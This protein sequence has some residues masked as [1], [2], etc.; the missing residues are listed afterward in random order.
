MWRKQTFACRHNRSPAVAL[1]ASAFKDEIE[2]VF[3]A[4]LQD[5]LFCHPSAD[6]V[7]ELCREL[8]SPTV[9]LEV[10]QTGA[11]GSKQRDEAMVARPSVVG[12][13]PAEG[14]M[15]QSVGMQIAHEL[16]ANLLRFGRNDNELFPLT[17]S[18]CHFEIAARYG[19]QDIAPVSAAM[20]PS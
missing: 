6:A 3:I 19:F 18:F 13:G 8:L 11:V 4:P 5:T 16:F 17:Y 20:R 14:N 12:A 1:D 15:A 2:M 10:E 9:E 7:V